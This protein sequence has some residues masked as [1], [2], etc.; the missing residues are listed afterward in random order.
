MLRILPARAAWIA[1]SYSQTFL[2]T[3]AIKFLETPSSK[4]AASHQYGLIGATG[5]IYIGIGVST[6]RSMSLIADFRQVAEAA[7]QAK[8]NRMVTI[9]RGSVVALIY[10]HALLYPSGADDLPAV[11]LMS[12]DVDQLSNALMY[13]SELFAIVTEIGI[14]IGLLWRQMGPVALAPIVLTLLSAWADTLLAKLQSKSRGVWLQ[15]MQQRVGLTSAVLGS[16]R[17][18]K[19]GGMTQVY[20]TTLQDERVHEIRKAIKFRWLTVWQNT[21]GECRCQVVHVQSLMN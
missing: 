3:A 7:T 12:A 6:F 1:L 11:T 10:E 2:I 21:L 8:R 20:A 13:A 14:G 18:V 4:R 15:A 16:M 19:L 17:S 5:L 9:F